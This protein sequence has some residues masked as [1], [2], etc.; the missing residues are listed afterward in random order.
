MMSESEDKSY[1]KHQ[2]GKVFKKRFNF[3]DRYKYNNNLSSNVSVRPS[4]SQILFYGNSAMEFRQSVERLESAFIQ[5]IIRP[6]STLTPKN[7]LRSLLNMDYLSG[8]E[9]PWDSKAQVPSSSAAW[10]TMC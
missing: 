9:W 8:R 4:N 6:S 3:K 1:K 5:A 2:H 7:T 10:P